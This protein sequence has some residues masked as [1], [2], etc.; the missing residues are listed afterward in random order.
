MHKTIKTK[1]FIVYIIMKKGEFMKTLLILLVLFT[2]SFALKITNIQK[3]KE[4]TNKKE[5]VRL[6]F[7][8]IQKASLSA[9]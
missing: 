2:L 8:Q 3:P 1:I 4:R 7:S 9:L 5:D 6:I